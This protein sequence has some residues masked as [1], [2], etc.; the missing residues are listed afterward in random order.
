MAAQRRPSLQV[1]G[2][3]AALLEGLVYIAN[4][5]LIMVIL[6]RMGMKERYYEEPARF[7]TFA[8]AHQGFFIAGA[9]VFVAAALIVLPIVL[10]LYERLRE[11]S[12]GL[13]TTATVLGVIATV[14]L[15]LNAFVQ[16]VEFRAPSEW[17]TS[18]NVQ[19]Q[20]Y[21]FQVYDVTEQAGSLC[22]GLWTLLLS[23]VVIGRGGL[24]GWLG[25]FGVLVGLADFLALVGPPVGAVLT[26][27]WFIAVGIILVR[28]PSVMAPNQSPVDR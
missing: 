20:A 9:L 5:I 7:V 26:I 4:G 22:L 27:V 2:G 24:P 19:A 1:A 6:P 11:L 3:I 23:W 8:T 28:A 21:A 17:S 12:P 15:L 25:Y 14:M 13:I 16:Y 10:G 18:V